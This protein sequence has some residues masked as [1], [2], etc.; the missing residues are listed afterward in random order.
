MD[1]GDSPKPLGPTSTIISL[2]E[3]RKNGWVK[4]REEGRRGRGREAI[5]DRTHHSTSHSH[6]I[7]NNIQQS[8]KIGAN[9]LR[10]SRFESVLKSQIN[11]SMKNCTA[12]SALLD[13]LGRIRWV[14][15]LE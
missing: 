10:F 14:S 11:N 7:T 3:R 5:G 9:A 13:Y 2:A 4:E 15:S 8:L 1:E 12:P 6:Q